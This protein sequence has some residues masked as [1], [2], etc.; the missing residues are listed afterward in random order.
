MIKALC[1]VCSST[2]PSFTKEHKIKTK[3]GY[4]P[5]LVQDVCFRCGYE[6]KAYTKDFNFRK[7]FI[8]V[9]APQRPIARAK[10][11]EDKNTIN[12]KITFT[13][14]KGDL[15]INIKVGKQSFS[16]LLSMFAE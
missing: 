13:A 8:V 7:P 11:T 1:P 2:W 12:E 6:S 15:E 3:G 4:D 16:K 5:N 14:C 9:N 10:L